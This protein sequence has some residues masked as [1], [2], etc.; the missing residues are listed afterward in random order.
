[1]VV[2]GH[3][4]LFIERGGKRILTFTGQTDRLES[5]AAALAT[6]IK[7]GRVARMHVNHV[8]GTPALHTQ[9]GTLL[10]MQGFAATPRGLRM[11]YDPRSSTRA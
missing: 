2:D 3:L 1:V 11:N 5:A 8:D 10:G 9:F 6:S 7:R 4:A